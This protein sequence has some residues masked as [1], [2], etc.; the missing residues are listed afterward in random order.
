[1]AAIPLWATWP[2]LATLSREVPA[3]ASQLP[4]FEL[5]AIAFGTGAALLYACDRSKPATQRP[6][7]GL[8]H[9]VMIAMAVVGYLV[10]NAFYVF[11][12]NRIPAAQANL[13]SYL[14]P[15][16]IVV[17]GG[18]LGLIP[19]TWRQGLGVGLG[20]SGAA[21]VIGGSG[22]TLS[23][24][25]I[26]LALASGLT[27]AAFCLF[28]LYEGENASNVLA[29]GFAASAVIGAVL[30]V[31]L[32]TT[33]IPSTASL[34][35]AQ[36]IGVLPLALGAWAWDNGIRRGDRR[37]L[38]VLA[39]ATPLASALILILCGYAIPSIGL[40]LGG[41]LIVAAGA[42]SASRQE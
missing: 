21:L 24:I 7:R 19:V 22:F 8:M 13:I 20:L 32:E 33:V 16:M 9:G 42:V 3:S 40:V 10:S 39:Y 38:A 11:A 23:W 26:A 1:M 37:M 15:V 34:A 12:M 27:W 41:A 31:V 30:H 17:M 6:T 5:L 18:A 29:T 2:L 14:W 4:T 28:R 35:F 25:G 36:L